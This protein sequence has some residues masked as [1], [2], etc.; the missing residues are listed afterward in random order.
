MNLRQDSKELDSKRR[1]WIWRLRTLKREP[2]TCNS[3]G[4]PNRPKRSSKASIKR[5]MKRTRSVSRIKF[6]NL[7]RM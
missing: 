3:T 1:D 6:S 7:K 4:L 5:K 2:R